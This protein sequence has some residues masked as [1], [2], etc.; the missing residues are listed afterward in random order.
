[1]KRI[2]M[3]LTIG[4]LSVGMAGCG[5]SDSDCGAVEAENASLKSQVSNLQSRL[6]TAATGQDSLQSQL[7]SLQ[8]QYDSLQEQL[9]SVQAD[10]Q[11]LL[12]SKE[13]D[14]RDPT[15]EELRAFLLADTTDEREY[16]ADEFDCE[17][18]TVTLRWNAALRGFRSAYVALGFES[19]GTGHALVAFDTVDQGLIYVDD[20][21]HDA[22]AYVEKGKT[23][24]AIRL[25][26]VKSKYI[27]PGGDPAE[28]W[29]QPLNYTE[30]SG[31]IFDYPYY[32]AYWE[33][34]RFYRDSVSAYNTE[35]E[36]YN[37]AV[38]AYNQDP[39]S[40]SR[41]ELDNWTEKLQDWSVNLEALDADLGTT[42]I[43]PM[44]KVATIEVYWNS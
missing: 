21:G 9:D 43:E 25:A 35:V 15:W 41:P 34:V 5:G 4:A 12:D 44:G 6:D 30:Y 37:D 39:E 11:S 19:G 29:R 2:L 13:S 3:L 1:M 32:E 26:G 28:F 22:I 42:R 10:Y 36:A 33:R 38:T 24:G 18:F 40:Y 20:T 16:I 8:E 14:L 17:G 31:R 23:Y 7:D 27:E